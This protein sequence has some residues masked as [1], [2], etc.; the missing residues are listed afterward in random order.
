MKIKRALL[1]NISKSLFLWGI[2]FSVT[3]ILSVF[4]NVI[5]THNPVEVNLKN[6]YSHPGAN[7]LLG[8]DNMG[9]DIFSRILHGGRISLSVSVVSVLIS[10]VVGVLFG[11]ISA[12]VGGWFDGL[13]MRILDALLAIPT[14][15][16]MLALQAVIHGGV[17]SMILIIGLTG[18]MSTARIVR[19]QFIELKEKE[20]VQAAYVMGTPH[21]KIILNHLLRNSL[22]GIF[23]IAIFNC[24][25]AVFTEVSL[26]FLGIGIPP[27]IPSWGNMLNNAQNDILIGAWWV[28]VFPGTMIVLSLLAINFLGE[29]LK[30]KYGVQGGIN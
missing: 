5:S 10:T 15:I 2:V 12:Y 13:M 14:L 3:V 1:K 6:V 29:A 19:S 11:G 25:H 26:S 9:R 27:Q 22:S 28:G 23:V 18:W 24:A 21:R 4:A 16:I 7:N 8:T 20:F 17:V 30:K